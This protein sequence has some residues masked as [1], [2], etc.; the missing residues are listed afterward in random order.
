MRASMTGGLALALL[1]AACQTAEEQQAVRPTTAMDGTWASTDGVFV[2]NF[3]NGQF[4]S[5]FTKTNEILAQGRYTVAGNNV[6]MQW[7]SV[8]AQA[9]RSANC[10]MTGANTVACTQAGG[11]AFN[12]QKSA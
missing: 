4:V 5:R 9:E 12:L 2:A 3:Q 10:L 7:I 8:Q 1:L 11:G 6:T